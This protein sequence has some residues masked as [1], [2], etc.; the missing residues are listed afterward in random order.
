MNSNITILSNVY[1][2]A[3]KDLRLDT[4]FTSRVRGQSALVKLKTEYEDITLSEWQ[5]NMRKND[6]SCPNARNGEKTHG[7]VRRDGMLAWE[8]RC[9]NTE[10]ERFSGCTETAKFVREL[11]PFYEEA[12]ASPIEFEWLGNV[13]PV[14]ENVEPIKQ[15]DLQSRI[16]ENVIP[17]PENVEPAQTELMPANDVI[18]ASERQDSS[19]LYD[20][21]TNQINKLTEVTQKLRNALLN[22][23]THEA[24]DIFAQEYEKI[25]NIGRLDLCKFENLEGMAAILCISGGEAEYA[26]H[27][28]HRKRIPHALLREVGSPKSIDRCVADCLWD[29]KS[30]AFVTR[31]DFV[32]RFLKR[33]RN[34]SEEAFSIFEALKACCKDQEDH[35]EDLDLRKLADGLSNLESNLPDKLVNK[36]NTQLTVSTIQ[37]AKGFE[38]DCVYL[39][40]GGFDPN[41]VT[42]YYNAISRAKSE[43][44][45]ISPKKDLYVKCSETNDNRHIQL[46]KCKWTHPPAYYCLHVAIGLPFDFSKTGFVKGAFLDALNMQEYIAQN[47]KIGDA[48]DIKL[49]N[50]EYQVVHKKNVIGYMPPDITAEFKKIASESRPNSKAPPS[51]SK[52]Y[53]SNVITIASPQNPEN[54]SEFFGDAKFWLGVELTGFPKIDWNATD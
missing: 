50:G 45:R 28:L 4:E 2:R 16:D 32:Q 14:P 7:L 5:E 52:V 44:Y 54:V 48:V 30:T 46:Q 29:Y 24:N 15:A 10:C 40:D 19:S 26:S 36:N 49:V 12:E 21:N 9:E 18:A 17:I 38:F 25:V 8:G 51:L 43:I 27:V 22:L 41:H 31:D 35:A 6:T 33:V 42:S 53:V 34:N 23:P 39:L 37:N 1:V 20:D 47:V 11:E 13:I 3:N